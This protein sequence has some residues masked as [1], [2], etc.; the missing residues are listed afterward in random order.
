MRPWLVFLH[1]ELVFLSIRVVFCNLVFFFVFAS[2]FL[3]CVFTLWSMV[4]N[5]PRTNLFVPV[6]VQEQGEH[7]KTPEVFISLNDLELLCTEFDYF[8]LCFFL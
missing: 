5:N 7:V 1:P 4:L 8:D 3:S 6:K 2:Y